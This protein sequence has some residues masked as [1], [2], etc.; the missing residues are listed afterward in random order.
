MLSPNQTQELLKIIDLNHSKFIGRE[1]GPKFL[2]DSDKEILEK[3]GVDWKGLY[4]QGSDSITTS[5]HL[6]MLADSLKENLHTTSY[7]QLKEYVEGGKYIPL[8]QRELS[9]IDVVK[10]QTLKDIRTLQGKIFND[11]NQVVVS[12]THEGQIDFLK[13]KIQEGL[14]KKKSTSQITSDIAH[15]TGDWNRNFHRIV[16]YNLQT[17]YELGKAEYFKSVYGDEVL[18]YKTVFEKA[19]SHCIKAYLTSGVGSEPRVFK[20]STLYSNGTNIGRKVAEWLPVVGPMHPYCRCSLHVV[21]PGYKWNPSTKDF[22]VPSKPKRVR[23]LIDIT[24]GD[25]VYQV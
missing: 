1:L 3:N 10:S 23:P 11:V 21:T 7:S 5:F 2:S 6:G 20:L 19:C 17:S 14:R 22:D 16:E 15:L 12:N 25:T 9:I 4:S 8:T 18:V 24:V 13:E